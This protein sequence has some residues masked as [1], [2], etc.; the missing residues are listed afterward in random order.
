MYQIWTSGQLMELAYHPE[1][2]NKNFV[3]MTDVDM[4]VIDPNKIVPIGMYLFPFTGIFNGNGHVISN[5]IYEKENEDYVGLFGYV[6]YMFSEFNEDEAIIQNLHMININIHGQNFVGGI[7]GFCS[8]T[9]NTCSVA[10]NIQGK[11]M[12]GGLVGRNFGIIRQCRTDTSVTG[13]QSTGGLVGNNGMIDEYRPGLIFSCYT[14]GNVWGDKNIGGLVGLSYGWIESCYSYSQVVGDYGIGGLVGINASRGGIVRSY[15]KGS[16]TGNSNIG[17]LVGIG[18]TRCTFMSFWD[19]DTSSVLSSAGGVGKITAHMFVAETFE[20]WGLS[21]D[22]TINEGADYP[23]LTWENVPGTQIVGQPYTYGGGSGQPEDPYQLWSAEQFISITDHYEDFD[24]CFIL[25]ADIDLNDIDPYQIR[26][27]G[28]HSMP[29][30]GIF[31]G[32]YHTIHNFHYEGTNEDWIGFFGCLGRLKSDGS[33]LGWTVKNLYLV[34]LTVTGNSYVGGLA[35]NC[36]GGFLASCSI[37]GKVAGGSDV[38]GL[39][40]HGFYTN[41]SS[42]ST[43]GIVEGYRTVGG[44]IGQQNEGQITQCYSSCEVIGH[45]NLGGLVGVNNSFIDNSYA[46][47]DVIGEDKT[48]WNHAGLVTIYS[49]QVGGLIGTNNGQITNCY[50]TGKVTGSELTG[51]LVG[52]KYLDPVDVTNVAGSLWD[53][54]T[55]GQISSVDG[56]GKTTVEMQTAGTFLDAGWDFVNETANGTDDIWWILE[57]QDYPRLWW[58]A[59]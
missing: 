3:L 4:A 32:N 34:N 54:D 41:I 27:I 39:V 8:G 15:S 7:A 37:S 55:S 53:I 13:E 43:S 21:G 46:V 1:D 35:G 2:Y 12:I 47:C 45:E 40:G 28:T 29:F 9:I 42:S 14:T 16:V 10:G 26:P 38:G 25:M 36:Y 23:R 11:E 33:V 48:R 31:N 56:D 44:L 18:E 57:G 20:D 19:I 30:T 58:E 5:F 6:G 17:G 50:S 24:K 49:N 52:N 59:E 22:W 51:G